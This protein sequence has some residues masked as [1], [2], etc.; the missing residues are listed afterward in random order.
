MKLPFLDR[1]EELARLVR[2]VKRDEGAFGVLYGR[3]RCG[4][5]RLLREAVPSETSVFFVGDDRE[6]T[7]QRAG[8]ASEI[9]RFLEGFGDVTYSEWDALLARWWSD[10]PPG[11]VLIL[12]ELPVDGRP[13]AGTAQRD[14]EARRSR[15]STA[16][17]PVGG[18]LLS[19][20][21]AGPGARPIRPPLWARDRDLEDHPARSGLDRR[22]AFD[23]RPRGCGGGVR[24]LGR[25]PALLG[26]GGR[27]FRPCGSRPFSR[28]RSAGSPARGTGTSLA[29]RP[30]RHLP[31]R[32]GAQPDRPRLP[33]CLGDCRP[34]GQTGDLARPAL[35]A[36]DGDGAGRARG[37]VRGRRSGDQAVPLPHLRSLPRV[38]GFDSSSRIARGWKRGSWRRSNEASLPT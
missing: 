4:K 37:A 10:A 25:G 19:A 12:D 26:A 36:T 3:R 15:P 5:S 8:L 21:D 31:G 22:S 11:A 29:R 38:S 9:G 27:P 35:A 20:H 14:P 30:A 34:A 32:I 24:P 2:L 18:G 1:R 6:A 23:R 17:S 7:L 33:P 28:P 13:C 16:C